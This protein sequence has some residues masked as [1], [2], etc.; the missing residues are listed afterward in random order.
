MT[1]E[2]HYIENCTK[3]KHESNYDR[4]LSKCNFLWS[5][6]STPVG[7]FCKPGWHKFH[8]QHM[9]ALHTDRNIK[10]VLLGDSLIQGLTRY[11]KVW[12]LFFGK[13][14]L[15]CGIRADKIENLLR[16]AENLEF[17]PTIRQVVIHC[18]NSNIELN[19]PNDIANG[20]LCS[21]L[22]IKRRNSTANVYV[23]G[24]LPH[25]FR[26]T[27][28]RNKIKEANELIKE[29]CLSISTARINYIEQDRDW[30]DKVN[31]L[32]TKYYYRDHL[33]LVE[34]GN[35]KLSNTIIK[36]IKHCTLTTPMNT[37]K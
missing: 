24:L 9:S 34:R 4:E 7:R 12:N 28:I 35:K 29:K 36:A 18:G 21:A 14:T 8:L 10:T 19:T 37:Q 2:L 16:R 17:P 25:D 3:S 11:T 26:E 15:N 6:T 23:I 30:I 33:H 32:R 1:E 13:D 20:L 27:H 22:T 31:C 5:Q